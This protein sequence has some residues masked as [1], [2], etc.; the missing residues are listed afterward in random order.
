MALCSE[1]I[2]RSSAR[3]AF[4]CGVGGGA[5]EVAG[6]DDDFFVGEGDGGAAVEGGEGGFKAGA[7]GG[8]DDEEVDVGVGG[9][10]VHGGDVGAGVVG[11]GLDAGEIIVGGVGPDPAG[12]KFTGLLLEEVEV[13]AGGEGA[14]LKAIGQGADDVEG[15]DADAA[16]AAEEGEAG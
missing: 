10:V 5:D 2:G 15:L 11:D 3:P 14:D 7:A 9:D 4:A 6:H 13:A 8:G 16:G 12:M 1:S